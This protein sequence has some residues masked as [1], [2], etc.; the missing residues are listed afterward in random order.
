VVLLS[1]ATAYYKT[2][3]AF[4]VHKRD[5]L[6]ERVEE[7]RDSQEEAG[8]QFRT[9]L[10]RFRDVVDFEGGE[11]EARYEQ[12][13]SE[14]ERSDAKAQ[15]VSQRIA[16]VEKVAEDLFD[17]WEGE[18]DQYSDDRLRRSSE[19]TLRQT[20]GKYSDLIA[21]MRRAESKMPPVLSRLKDQVL[22]L[23]HNLNARAIASLEGTAADL[24]G[25]VEALLRELE[26]SIAEANAFIEDLL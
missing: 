15:E 20:R 24:Q 13:N 22:F 23:K 11:L 10:E 19:R 21:A 2:M 6:V 12:L 3:E 8:E 7:A 4:G 26:K 5:I 9:A 18:L 17:E 16:S 14:Y 25:E 1:C